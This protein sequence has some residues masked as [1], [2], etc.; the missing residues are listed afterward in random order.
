VP[1]DGFLDVTSASWRSAISLHDGQAQ[2][3]A[4]DT[5]AQRAVEGLEDQLAL[6]LGNAGAVVLD[7]QHHD[8]AEGVGQHAGTVTVPPP[9]VYCT[10]LSTRLRTSSRTSTGCPACVRRAPRGRPLVAEVDALVHGRGTKSRTTSRH[11]GQV[12]GLHAAHGLAGLRRG[13][14]PAAG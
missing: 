7:L 10:A 5:R 4:V 9:G 13:P 14:W 3:G 2:A 8:L 11:A 12:Q 1:L 6:G